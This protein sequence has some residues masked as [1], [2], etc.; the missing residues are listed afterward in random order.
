MPLPYKT[1]CFDYNKIGCKSRRD[2]IDRCKVEM[3]FKNYNGS[4]PSETIINRHNNNKFKDECKDNDQEYC[5]QKHKSPDCINEY[6]SAKLM[7]DKKHNEFLKDVSME[8]FL[9]LFDMSAFKRNNKNAKSDINLMSEIEIQFNNEPDTIYTHSPQQY[10]I[11]FVCL[12][13]GIISLWTGFSIFSIYAH[14]KHF[15]NRRQNKI[16][17]IKVKIKNNNIAMIARRPGSPGFGH[18][19]RA[20]PRM[21]L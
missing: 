18:L 1:L 5:E 13:G 3:T 15:L 20:V 19:S 6:Y 4:F 16:R 2:C 8:Y 21:R 11:E 12:I 17:Q 10:P 7:F 14:G 9:S